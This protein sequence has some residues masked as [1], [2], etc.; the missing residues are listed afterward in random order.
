MSALSRRAA[1]GTAAASLFAGRALGGNRL[2][3]QFRSSGDSMTLAE[4]RALNGAD[5]VP[6]L[7]GHLNC[8]SMT[9]CHKRMR[10]EHGIWIPEL[11]PVFEE[12]DALADAGSP[13]RN[14]DAS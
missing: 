8:G 3:A 7:L 14:P 9:N 2:T 6:Q 13:D 5:A 10:E 4:F 1:L 11:V 12:L